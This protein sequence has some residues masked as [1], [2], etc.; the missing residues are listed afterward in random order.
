MTLYLIS[1][2]KS[3]SNSNS[4]FTQV[5]YDNL[6]QYVGSYKKLGTNSY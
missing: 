5:N 1:K 3:E 6:I 4:V 2:K